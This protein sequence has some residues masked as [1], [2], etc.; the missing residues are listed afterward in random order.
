ME[1]QEQQ[2]QIALD[3]QIFALTNANYIFDEEQIVLFL[4]SG[5]SA[6]RYMLTPK[7]AKRF[8]LLL[9]KCIAEY[10][11]KFGVLKT[12]LPQQNKDENTN[13]GRGMGFT[14]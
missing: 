10:E 5:N 8:S 9:D 11:K 7:H 6:R 3:Q 14:R 12:D 1:N 13:T 2:I 4:H